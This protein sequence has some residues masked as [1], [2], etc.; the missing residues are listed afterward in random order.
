MFP[1]TTPLLDLPVAA[2]IA[3]GL[4]VVISLG[5]LIA[6]EYT[7]FT[8]PIERLTLPRWAWALIS[9]VQFIGPIAF[10]VAGRRPPTVDQVGTDVNSDAL[11]TLYPRHD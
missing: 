2:W 3:L 9:L 5:L 4:L 1:L 11:T 7:I 8:T 6:A 10:F